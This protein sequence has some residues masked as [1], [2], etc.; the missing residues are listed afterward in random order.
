MAERKPL[1]IAVVGSG[2]AGM[3]AAA[4]LLGTPEGTWLEG[5]SG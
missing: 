5:L 4:H 2:P 1:R 3:Y